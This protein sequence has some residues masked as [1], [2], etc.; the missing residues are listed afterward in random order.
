MT[1][2]SLSMYFFVGLANKCVCIFFYLLIFAKFWDQPFKCL[3]MFVFCLFY[4]GFLVT[5]NIRLKRCACRVETV[6]W[7]LLRERASGGQT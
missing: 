5:T 6:F 4:E 7:L 1:N 3:R 2:R